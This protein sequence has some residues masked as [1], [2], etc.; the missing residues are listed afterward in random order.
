LRNTNEFTITTSWTS[1]S[2]RPIDSPVLIVINPTKA[3]EDWV[4]TWHDPHG[5][6]KFYLRKLNGDIEIDF[7]VFWEDI[8]NPYHPRSL[9][10]WKDHVVRVTVFTNGTFRIAVFMAK[11]GYKHSFYLNV[12]KNKFSNVEDLTPVYTK[13]YDKYWS[14]SAGEYLYEMSDKIF[15]VKI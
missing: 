9:D 11:G 3:S 5:T 7:L 6:W 12:P 10:D 15:Y 2:Q 14:Q 4:F 1:W 8:F 13:S